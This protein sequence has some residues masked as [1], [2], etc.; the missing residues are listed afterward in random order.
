MQLLLKFLICGLFV[1]GGVQAKPRLRLQQVR[2]HLN[3]AVIADVAGDLADESP[4]MSIQAMD[5]ANEDMQDQDLVPPALSHKYVPKN[6]PHGPEV[7]PGDPHEVVDDI[8]SDHAEFWRPEPPGMPV[9]SVGKTCAEV[10]SACRIT[11]DQIMG[12]KCMATCKLGTDSTKCLRKPTGWS[13]DQQTSRPKE[14]WEGKCNVGRTDCS[15][16]IDEE[17]QKATDRCHGDPVCLHKLQKAMSKSAPERFCLNTKQRLS[18]CERF[19]HVPKENDWKCYHTLEEC[20]Q[21]HYTKPYESHVGT[22]NTPCV[23]CEATNKADPEKDA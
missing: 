4:D 20:K 3:P 10:C 15:E 1:G 9:G 7:S 23:W 16:C 17:M 8:M 19:T 22:I 13:N 11:A 21:M 5:E 6:P 14:I 12:C 18:S 2:D